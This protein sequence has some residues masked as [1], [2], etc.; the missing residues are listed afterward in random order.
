MSTQLDEG[1]YPECSDCGCGNLSGSHTFCD[2]C[3]KEMTIKEFLEFKR[4]ASSNG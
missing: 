1:W 4:E 3:L 2:D